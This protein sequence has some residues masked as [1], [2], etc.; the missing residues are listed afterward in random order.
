MHH[1]LENKDEHVSG[2][3]IL[4]KERRDAFHAQDHFSKAHYPSERRGSNGK[5]LVGQKA[6]KT[7]IH[8]Q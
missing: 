2:I 4:L 7:C 5:L 6:W 8:F 1:V 3:P